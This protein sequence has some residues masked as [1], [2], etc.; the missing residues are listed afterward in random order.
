MIEN[1]PRKGKYFF[2]DMSV[3]RFCQENGYSYVA[4]IQRIS[5]KSKKEHLEKEKIINQS[6][7][8]YEK[9]LEIKQINQIFND[10][11]ENKELDIKKICKKL[12][13]SYTSYQSLLESGFTDEQAINL[14]WYFYE[15]KDE[16]DNKEIT[17]N[18]LVRLY[19]IIDSIKTNT[20]DINETDIY[21]LIGIFKSKL[22]DTRNEIILKQKKYIYK[23][24]NTLMKEYGIKYNKTT[25]EE[26][27]NEIRYYLLIFLERTNLNNLGQIIKFMNL[28]VKGYL[29]K[30]IKSYYANSVLSLDS[31]I[32][33]SGSN[34]SRATS[35]HNFVAQNDIKEESFSSKMQS[36]L[37]NLNKE[38]LQLI[39]LKYQEQ[40]TLEELSKIFNITVE[41]VEEREERILEQLRNNDKTKQFFK[42]IYTNK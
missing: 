24:A 10:L 41:E 6:I 16:E 30:Y 32:S 39:I 12:K 14:I 19:K 7:K 36:I 4:I 17:D 18:Q 26:L 42:I 5:S 2:N 29:R 11:K 9:K 25:E 13:I 38:D 37:N 15:S 34:S 33:K 40:Y 1:P 8:E 22:Y 28:T 21:D 23:T 20:I 31:E 27:A 3:R 35:L